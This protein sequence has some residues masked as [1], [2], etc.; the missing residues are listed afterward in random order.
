MKVALDA[1]GGD[2]APGEIVQGALDAVREAGIEVILVGPEDKIQHELDRPGGALPGISIHPATEIITNDEA[3]VAAVRRKKDSSMV[4]AVRLVKEGAA[5]A[6][7]SAGSTGALLAAGLFGLGRMPGVDRPA[8]GAAF[9]T[10]P[11]RPVLVLDIGA[12]AECRPENL[13]QFAIMG[14]IYAEVVLGCPNPRVGLL[15][16]GTEEG[17]GNELTRATFP[18]LQQVEGL[19]FAGNIEARDLPM[20]VVD[21]LVCDGFVGNVVL[22]LFEG[23]GLSFFGMVRDALRSTTM[24]KLGG[25]LARPALKA[26]ARRLDYA[27]YGGAPLVGLKAPAIKCHG[28]SNARAIRS[29][30]LVT[31][32]LVQARAVSRMQEQIAAAGF[33]ARKGVTSEHE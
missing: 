11:G 20:N 3:P 5:D 17:K 18:L 27:E 1:M 14:R 19:N 33:G 23:L 12:N 7:V 16:N 29:G 25:L 31:R 9:P 22:K 2:N 4:V 30:L 32:D 15:S 8:L 28:S 26:M 24:A 6:V 21:V 13:V 10:R